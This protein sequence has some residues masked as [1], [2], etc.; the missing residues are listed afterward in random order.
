MVKSLDVLSP[1]LKINLSQSGYVIYH[2]SFRRFIIDQL[3]DNSLLVEKK[4]FRPVFEWFDSKIFFAY[5][6]AY[7]YYLP[8]L[9]ES[10]E[11]KKMM[12][13]LKFNF[14]TDSVINGQ[15]WELIEKNYKYFVKAACI[16]KDFTR[17]VY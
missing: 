9:F 15:P 10:G 5:R 3:K 12:H 1:V 2:E 14:V 16:L 17:I 4:V 7:R 11:F 13:F 8:F 6:K